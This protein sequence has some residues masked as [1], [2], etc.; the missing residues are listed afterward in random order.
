MTAHDASI[1]IKTKVKSK[2]NK[3]KSDKDTA[4]P[5]EKEL[6]YGIKRL[7][8]GDLAVESEYDSK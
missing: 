5:E 4:V 2:A 8:L 1:P 7:H 6:T 3:P